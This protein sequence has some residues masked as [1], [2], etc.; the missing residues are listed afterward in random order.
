MAE[1]NIEKIREYEKKIGKPYA[2]WENNDK[3]N[4]LSQDKILELDNFVKE[5]TVPL[6]NE[7]AQATLPSQ[8]ESELAE[9]I[10]LGFEVAYEGN[11]NHKYTGTQ[12]EVILYNKEN[13]LFYHACST[14]HGNSQGIYQGFEN[15]T[16]YGEIKEYKPM[17]KEDEVLVT[18]CFGQGQAKGWDNPS[19]NKIKKIINNCEFQN[20]WIE[21]SN[22][23]FVNPEEHIYT[24]NPNYYFEVVE[25]KINKMP[26]EAQQIIGNT[27]TKKM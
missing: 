11:Y 18:R 7:F 16:L 4:F 6:I 1:L 17:S 9:I 23:W 10:Q 20:P 5:N 13:G 2:Q 14:N 26:E 22:K 15:S 27:T 21:D 24:T 12:K 25:N 19:V 3:L 8:F